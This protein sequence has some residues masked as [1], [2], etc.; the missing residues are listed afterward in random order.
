MSDDFAA[1]GGAS[2]LELASLL[3]H[4]LLVMPTNS[5]L[6]NTIHDKDGPSPAIRADVHD[7][8]TGEA[9]EDVLLFSQGLVGSL[10]SRIGSKVLATLGQGVAKPGRNA[11]WTLEDRS[12]DSQA[13][14]K[15]RAYLDA[16]QGG[17]GFAAPA[18]S[19]PAARKNLAD[20][21]GK[22]TEVPF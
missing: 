11:P 14:A 7:L 3:G 17:G 20:V 6:V 22:M 4:L 8:T 21:F 13:K 10:R 2:R 16:Y 19:E 9:Y 12:T 1:P 5:E 18:A 15:A